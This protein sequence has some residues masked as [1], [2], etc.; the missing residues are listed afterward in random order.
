MQGTSVFPNI[1]LNGS[2]RSISRRI[3]FWAAAAGVWL[4][5]AAAGASGGPPAIHIPQARHEFAPVP[6]GVVV[7][8]DFPIL[9]RG[10]ADLEILKVETG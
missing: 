10:G 9:N 3:G 5:A 2:I 7:S 6:E 4:L 8:H 1:R